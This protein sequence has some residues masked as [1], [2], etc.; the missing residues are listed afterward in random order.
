MQELC[1]I[2]NFSFFYDKLRFSSG[3]LLACCFP[4]FLQGQTTEP[5]I[6]AFHAGTTTDSIQVAPVTQGGMF[7]EIKSYFEE[8]S[9]TKPG[10][11]TQF[12]WVDQQKNGD[13]NV[14]YVF[15][16]KMIDFQMQTIIQYANNEQQILELNLG[17]RM[18]LLLQ[19]MLGVKEGK[20]HVDLL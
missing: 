2:L 15:A 11:I 13:L 19:I 3:L 4:I 6:H 7:L 14:R 10:S 1:R 12:Y 9:T 20:L 18:P 17:R 16:N 5:R 8:Y